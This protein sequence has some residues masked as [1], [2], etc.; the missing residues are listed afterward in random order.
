MARR[1]G[2]P[3][4]V[5]RDHGPAIGR[6]RI[7]GRSQAARQG[8]VRGLRRARVFALAREQADRQEHRCASC[9][10]RA[11]PRNGT[12]PRAAPADR[13]DDR[14]QREEGRDDQQGVDRARGMEERAGRRRHRK[15]Q[16]RDG[17][18]DEREQRQRPQPNAALNRGGQA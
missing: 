1:P 9:Q 6:E 11:Q 5:V 16:G 2:E 17:K 8:G 7:A 18:G 14:I 10:D 13:R 3:D 15:H 12:G 4:R